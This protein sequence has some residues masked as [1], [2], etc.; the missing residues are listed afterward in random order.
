MDIQQKDATTSKTSLDEIP[1]G[2][3]FLYDGKLT[4]ANGDDHHYSGDEGSLFWIPSQKKQRAGRK[5]TTCRIFHLDSGYEFE[6]PTDDL[7]DFCGD[8]DHLK[9]GGY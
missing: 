9:I 2:E 5:A 7:T 4:D 1:N 6:V 3:C 8:A